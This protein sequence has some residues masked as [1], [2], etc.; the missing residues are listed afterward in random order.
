MN[1]VIIAFVPISHKVCRS[2]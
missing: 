1:V 2:W